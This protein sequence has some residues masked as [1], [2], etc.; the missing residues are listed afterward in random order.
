[1]EYDRPPTSCLHC[2]RSW[3]VVS[4]V[5][6]LINW[7]SWA[8]LWTVLWQSGT[9]FHL[10][11]LP[12]IRSSLTSDGANTM[13]CSSIGSRLDYCNS[14]LVGNSEH[15]LDS[16]QP[17]QSKAARIVCNA[18]RHSPRSDLIHSLY[19]H[20]LPVRHRIE[21]KTTLC[22]K[23]VKLVTPSNLNNMLNRIIYAPLQT[24]ALRS[25]NMDLLTVPHT[26]TSLGLLRFS[27]AGP[28]D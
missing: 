2:A 27:V 26:D 13:A 16:I 4:I 14:L 5:P 22:F 25:S 20:W 3:V 19:I 8:W 10:R 9:N 11:A 21:F 28:Q 7:K 24:R 1:M 12:H 15:N 23:A 6:R 17:V 18:G